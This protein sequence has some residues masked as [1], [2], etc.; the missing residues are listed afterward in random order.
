M[1]ISVDLKENS[2]DILIEDGIL[3]RVGEYIDLNRKVM[4][5]TDDGV[6]KEYADRLLSQCPMGKKIVVEQ[7]EKS[8]SFST[9][10]RI[11]RKLLEN[12]FHRKDLIIA[13]GGG[14]IG[15]LAGF[16]A[17]TY[18]RGIDFVN[19]PTTTLSQIDSS[20]GGKTAI[21]L[22]DTKNI[23]GA[24]YQPKKVFID[25]KTLRTLSE[26]DFNNGMIEAL[27]AGLIY[28]KDIFELFE[29]GNIEERYRDIIIKSILVKKDVVEKDVKEQN[30]R[31]ILNFG[32]TIGHGIEGYFN[33]DGLLHGEAVALGILPMIEDNNLR[34]RTKKI[35]E[36]LN[37]ETDIK[38]DKEKVFQLMVKDKK[39]DISKITLVKV[40]ELGSAYLS[41]ET[42]EQC[43]KYLD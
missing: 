32:H 6:P 15:D 12:N 30:L 25:F 43:K 34:E 27:K 13:L 36:K 22:G 16:C 4:I 21:N 10:E 8:K 5:I 26:R 19:I 3:N 7:G 37:I 9:Y 2:Y 35:I 39:A 33:F 40:K 29:S 14:V 41:D 11:C 18:M 1:K 24:F 31:K 28:D 38:Y 17:S 42:F 23:I 20:I